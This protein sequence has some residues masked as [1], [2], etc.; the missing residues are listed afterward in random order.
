MRIIVFS[1]LIVWGAFCLKPVYGDSF[2]D[3]VDG[4]FD[5]GEYIAENAYGFIP[6][7]TIITEP[8][9]GGGGGIIGVFLHESEADKEARRKLALTSIDGGARMIPPAV[10]VIGGIATGNGTRGALLGHRQVWKQDHIRYMGGM[11]YG[12]VFM[13][14]Y[15]VFDGLL[16]GG[17]SLSFKTETKAWGGMQKLQFRVKD[18]PLFLGLSQSFARSDVSVSNPIVDAIFNLVLGKSTTASGLGL[19]AEYDARNNLFFPTDGYAV[20]AEYKWYRD[21]IGSDNDY[22]TFDL[23]GQIY[24][25]LSK[26]FTLAF[27]GDYQSLN[28]DDDLLPPL[29]RPFIRLRGIAA[30][31]YQDDNV[32]AIQ[33]QLMWHIN[34]R[35]TLSAFVGTGSAASKAS[36]LYEHSE[37]AYGVGWRYQIARRYGLHMGMDFAFSDEDSAFYINMG[38]GF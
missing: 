5:M 31:R 4:M 1:C 15:N 16:P 9:L 30:Y 6:V 3:P 8:A 25:P 24:F 18:T 23:G 13:D 2:S 20:S 33:T 27:A 12:D 17:E 34:Y 28:T 22:D 11:F 26:R 19:V 36:D 14:I 32:S 38:S 7:P 35:W 37:A 29:V 10:T 21:A